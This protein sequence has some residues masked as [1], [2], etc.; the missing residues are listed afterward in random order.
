MTFN[1]KNNSLQRHHEVRNKPVGLHK[2]L[3]SFFLYFYKIK[4]RKGQVFQERYRNICTLGKGNFGKVFLAEDLS[5][6]DQVIP[7]CSGVWNSRSLTDSCWFPLFCRWPLKWWINDYSKTAIRSSTLNERNLYVKILRLSW[8]I[9]TLY[10]YLM[11]YLTKNA[12]SLWWNTSKA[13][14]YLIASNKI[15]NSPNNSLEDGFEK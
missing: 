14:S 1:K 10:R 8:S 15:K 12:S 7:K 13:E 11:S 9:R 2:S 5:T 3:I 4:A 6:G